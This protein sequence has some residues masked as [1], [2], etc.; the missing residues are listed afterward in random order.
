MNHRYPTINKRN[1]IE[2]LLKENYYIN[3]IIGVYYSIIYYEIK[4]YNFS[5]NAFVIQKNF[6]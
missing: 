1:K 5:Y 2:I 4:R 3:K 6:A